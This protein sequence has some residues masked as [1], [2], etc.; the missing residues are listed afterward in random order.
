V[1][2]AT[3]KSI[4]EQWLDGRRP[5]RIGRDAW[6]DLRKALGAA[7]KTA[8]DYYLL[9]LLLGHELE[10]DR[11]LG[12]F[13]VELRGRV[14]TRD[15]TAAE[16]SLMEMSREYAAARGRGDADRAADC[17]RAVRHAAERIRMQLGRRGL[18]ADKR[19]EKQELLQW[20]RV[21]LETPELFPDWVALRRSQA[22]EGS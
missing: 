2:K 17:R 5:A 14:H 16:E 21:W 10:I 9:D 22:G 7:G 20:F 19:D 3:V 6:A 15:R 11:S 18:S 13:A 4:L 8:S 12:G 1:P